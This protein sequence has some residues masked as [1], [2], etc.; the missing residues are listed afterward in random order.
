VLAAMAPNKPQHR[1]LVLKYAS[2]LVAPA[3]ARAAREKGT[4]KR[5]REGFNVTSLLIAL[6]LR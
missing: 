5:R 6:V 4:N 1:Y 3:A 2:D